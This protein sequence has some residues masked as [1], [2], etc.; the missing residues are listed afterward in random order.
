MAVSAALKA[1]RQVQSPVAAHRAV[2]HRAWTTPPV[3]VII[4]TC[5]V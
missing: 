3:N 5:E 4:Q 1:K 2:A